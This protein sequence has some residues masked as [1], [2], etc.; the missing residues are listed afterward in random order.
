VS[1]PPVTASPGINPLRTNSKSRGA[2]LLTG[3]TRRWSQDHQL[4]APFTARQA[5]VNSRREG[6]H[7]SCSTKLLLHACP[8]PLLVPPQVW[9]V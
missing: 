8:F 1:F 9:C 7:G 5:E 6:Q 4:P 2:A 3:N